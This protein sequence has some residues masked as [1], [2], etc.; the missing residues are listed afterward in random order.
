M[1]IFRIFNPLKTVNKK[2][3]RAVIEINDGINNKIL[4]NVISIFFI[5]ILYINVIILIT[6]LINKYK[7]T[8]LANMSINSMAESNPDTGVINRMNKDRIVKIISNFKNPF[9]FIILIA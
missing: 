1:R 8:I 6:Y 4:L 5:I 3:I 2:R 7:I 9:I